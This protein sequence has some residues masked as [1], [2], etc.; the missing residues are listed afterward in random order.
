MFV[1]RIL[2]LLPY[3]SVAAEWGWELLKMKSIWKHEQ[4]LNKISFLPL[5]LD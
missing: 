1:K 2:K 3:I 5:F 4:I